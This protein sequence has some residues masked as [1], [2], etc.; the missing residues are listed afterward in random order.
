MY[1]VRSTG[2]RE[3]TV[4]DDVALY[5]EERRS[6]HVL[7]TTARFIWQSLEEP[8]TFDEL[9]FMLAETFQ[10]ERDVLR[11]DL[12]DTLD[13]FEAL[14]LVLTRPTRDDHAVS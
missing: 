11:K 9:L 5:V 4:G 12:R 14:S 8:L 3:K 13:R 2:V 6:I 1:F 10:V 7:N